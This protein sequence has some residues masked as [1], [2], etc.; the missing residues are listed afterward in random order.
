MRVSE[1]G[2]VGFFN[3]EKTLDC[4]VLELDLQRCV[5][6]LC[7]WA[8][9]RPGTLKGVSHLEVRTPD[10]DGRAGILLDWRDD[11]ACP[12]AAERNVAEQLSLDLHPTLVSNA[13]D[14]TVHQQRFVHCGD[15]H[16]YVPLSGFVQV[17]TAVNRL[18]IERLVQAALAAGCRSFLDLYGGAGNFALPL[19]AAGLSGSLVEINRDCVR[20]AE[21]SARS[22]HLTN[23]ALEPSDALT[24]ARR[25]VADGTRFDLVVIDPPR[26]GVREGLELISS[27]A[28]HAIA[29]CSCNL[30]T[31][32]R[33][34]RYLLD[35]GWRLQRLLGFD[36]FP[37]TRHQETLA[38]LQPAFTRMNRPHN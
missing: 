17:N 18:L 1:H 23:L 28:T 13:R 9:K 14:E 27:L 24:E 4:A 15:S 35:A 31:L 7:D 10:A 19:A 37:G 5:A 36:M 2:M 6:R 29:Y 21:R 34:L 32:E 22:R 20:A 33:D 26:A 25:W 30:A 8:L 16:W 38:W 3:P 12:G 11:T